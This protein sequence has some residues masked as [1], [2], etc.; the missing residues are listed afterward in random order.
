MG[1][2]GFSFPSPLTP[3][4]SPISANLYFPPFGKGGEGGILRR[5]RHVQKDRKRDEFLVSIGLKVLRFD[6]REILKETDAVAEV[7]YRRMAAQINS[8]IPPNPP[9]SKGGITKKSS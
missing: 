8:K 5:Y 6:S 7:I 1:Y 9:F 4:L 3:P 2:Q